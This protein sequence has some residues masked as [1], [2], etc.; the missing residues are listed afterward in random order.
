M[1]KTKIVCTLGPATEDSK[2]IRAL[3]RNGMN[4]A[5]FNMSHGTHESH[6][7]MHDLVIAEAFDLKLP[8]ASMLDTKGPEVRLGNFGGNGKVTVEDG[9]IF[10]LTPKDINGTMERASIT[11]K[12]LYKDVKPGVTL[13]LDDGNVSM[14]VVR[15]DEENNIICKVLHGGVL[16]NHKSVNIPNVK[17]SMPYISKEDDSDIRFA[18][19]EG[20][21]FVAASFVTCA[22]DVLAVREILAEEGRADIRIISKIENRLGVD[23][24]DEILAVSDGIMVARGDM[25]VEIPFEEIPR[26]QKMMIKKCAQ[27]AKPVI[28]ATQMLESMTH[29]PRPT[30]AETNDV[31][32]AIYDGTDAI[33]LSGETAA[34]DYPVE[35]VKTMAA[36]AE[37]TEAAID[38]EAAFRLAS[39]NEKLDTSTAIAHGA[40]STAFDLGVAAIL[41]ITQ[42]GGTANTVS[43]YRPNCEIIGCTPVDATY[44]QLALSWGVTPVKM[45]R[46]TD[47]SELFTQAIARARYK[48]SLRAGDGIVIT[49][50][51]PLGAVGKTNLIKVHTI[52]E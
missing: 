28:T 31:A 10:V 20:F 26:I 46:A 29:N 35:A 44:R 32:N 47:I 16:S 18:A 19:E 40:V 51:V 39:S 43:R 11:Y 50:G 49:A 33:M 25:G 1:R 14:K 38:Y 12:D 9:D 41:S 24:F 45:E 36:I 37:A 13:L 4:V 22:A 15:V 42:T 30:R 23:N 5:R 17:L 48:C 52:S 8:I 7:R 21:D 2:M 27:V 3:M 6:R 34:G